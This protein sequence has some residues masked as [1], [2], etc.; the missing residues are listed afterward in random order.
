M[1]APS[2][3]M[4]ASPSESIAVLTSFTEVSGL[5]SW[6]S[7]VVP[8]VKSTEGFRPL[9]DTSPIDSKASKPEMV[10]T[11]GAIRTNLMPV[12]CKPW[13]MS[14]RF[15][16]RVKTSSKNGTTMTFTNTAATIPIAKVIAKP[17]TGP[18]V[19]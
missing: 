15:I 11:T 5:L 3:L 2:P 19:Y 17:R 14:G 9:K 4:S 12:K 13:N 8:P 6:Y 10:R 1:V 16:L 18:L 7:A